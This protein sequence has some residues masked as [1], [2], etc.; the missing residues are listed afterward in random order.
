VSNDGTAETRGSNARS[1]DADV[2]KGGATMTESNPEDTVAK[3][4]DE[5]NPTRPT[6]EPVDRGSWK[7]TATDEDA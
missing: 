5:G 2:A 7:L 6:E 4:T 3:D 1:G